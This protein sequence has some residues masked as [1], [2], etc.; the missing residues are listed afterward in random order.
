MAPASVP[1]ST[2]PALTFHFMQ[3][4]GTL[5]EHFSQL[6]DGSLADS[7][8]R[9]AAL[10]CRGDLCRAD[11]P[12]SA[13]AGAAARARG[14]LAGLATDRAR[15]DA[16]QP[17]QH[18]ANHRDHA[19]STHAPRPRAF[20]KITT[21]V[22]VE[23]G[24]HNPLAAAIG[25]GGESEWRWPSVCWPSCRNARWCWPIGCMVRRVCGTVARR[26]RAGRSHFLLRARRDIKPQ[27]IQRLTDVSQL[28][29]VAVHPP[30]T[31]YRVLHWLEFARFAS[32]S[33]D[34]VIAPTS[35][36]C[37]RVWSRC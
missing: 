33:G 22:L 11:A 28:V 10:A 30:H 2:A 14:V 29:R 3:R 25:R 26:L 13:P 19:E 35:C 37:G 9:T 5:A 24:V 21:T 1:V 18:P 20:A 32:A 4:A 34:P 12:C 8:W 17:D 6:F 31:R 7:S 27:L 16:I 15:R 23:L 36:D